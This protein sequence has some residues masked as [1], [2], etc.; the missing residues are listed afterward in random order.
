MRIYVATSRRNLFQPAIVR[1]LRGCGHEVYD[2]KNPAADHQGFSWQSIDP[3]LAVV[4]PA[5]VPRCSGAPD[6]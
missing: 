6:C 3:A 4:E 5:G 2:F 1:A